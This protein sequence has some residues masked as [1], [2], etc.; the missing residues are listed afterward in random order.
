M[1][2]EGRTI[3]VGKILKYKP[4]GSAVVAPVVGKK[5]E[6]KGDGGPKPSG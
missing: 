5:E 1:R 6:V 2:D 4:A 3:A